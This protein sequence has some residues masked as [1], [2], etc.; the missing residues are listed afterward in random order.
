VRV[1]GAAMSSG[2]S[3]GAWQRGRWHDTV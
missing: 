2:G 3:G 1:A